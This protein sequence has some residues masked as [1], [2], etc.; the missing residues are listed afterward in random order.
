MEISKDKEEWPNFWLI[1]TLW[2]RFVW[3]EL[4]FLN[5]K[6]RRGW[7]QCLNYSKISGGSGLEGTL[8]LP[9]QI[10]QINH[11][12]TVKTHQTQTCSSSLIA[13]MLFWNLSKLQ[14]VEI[15]NFVF[16]TRTCSSAPCSGLSESELPCLQ[17]KTSERKLN[18]IVALTSSV[19]DFRQQSHRD[20]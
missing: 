14:N 18:V 1:C 19:G 7:R 11:I 12:Y 17:Q 10:N 3:S 6:C 20:N 16:W 5:L 13:A 15:P 4:H 2:H 8:L 9:L